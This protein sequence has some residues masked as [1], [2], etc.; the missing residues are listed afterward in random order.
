MLLLLA[1]VQF[2]TATRLG[3]SIVWGC[4]IVLCVGC[5]IFWWQVGAPFVSLCFVPFRKMDVDFFWW[6]S[7][8]APE[9][10]AQ[11]VVTFSMHGCGY[12]YC[13]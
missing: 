11:G 1:D 4:V 9:A 2:Q 10:G 13:S 8:E 5:F 12:A 6:H 7:D 3:Q